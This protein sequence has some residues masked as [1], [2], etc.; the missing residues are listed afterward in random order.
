MEKGWNYE[1]LVQKKM[2]LYERLQKIEDSREKVLQEQE[3]T[4]CNYLLSIIL[5]SER[6]SFD[7]KVTMKDFVEDMYGQDFL[8]QIPSIELERIEQTALSLSKLPKLKIAKD[9]TYIT[10]NDAIEIISDFLNDK[11]G[12]EHFKIFKDL[13]VNNSNYVFFTKTSSLSYV[14]GLDSEIF[15]HIQQSEDI[16]MLATIAHEFGH[17]YRMIKNDN[18]LLVNSYR[19]YESFFNEFNILL[20]LIKNDIYSQEATNYFLSLFDKMEKVLYMRYLI[21]NYKLNQIEQ[22]DRFTEM[23]NKLNVKKSFNIRRNQDLFDIYSTAMDMDLRTY[24]N[25]FMAVLN[26]INDYKKYELVISEIKDENENDIKK[27]LRRSKVEY[28]SYL[29]YRNLLQKRN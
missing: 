19:E 2:Q 10:V 18:K 25:S 27:V 28:E 20:W 15:V 14:T 12:N 1:Y 3:I 6:D 21:R 13:F 11:F 24:F 29:K 5:F 22:P 23:I 4:L 17:I 16:K 9:D 7:E 8:Y 26:N